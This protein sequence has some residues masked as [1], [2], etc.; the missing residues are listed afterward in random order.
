MGCDGENQCIL[1]ECGMT[2]PINLIAPAFA[3]MSAAISAVK[4]NKIR[5]MCSMLMLND[6]ATSPPNA[7]PSSAVLQVLI[8]RPHCRECC[9][10]TIPS[11]LVGRSSSRRTLKPSRMTSCLYD[12]NP[13]PQ[14]LAKTCVVLG[15]CQTP[16]RWV[17]Y[18]RSPKQNPSTHA[19]AQPGVGG[20][21]FFCCV[22]TQ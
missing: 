18:I 5:R 17:T 2:K 8:V 19:C 4:P 7:K 16:T 22:R 3:T 13:S 6:A 11:H 9:S 15:V 1:H 20:C 21:F 12:T 10:P 14:P